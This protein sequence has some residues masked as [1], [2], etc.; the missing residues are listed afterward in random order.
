MIISSQTGCLFIQSIKFTYIAKAQEVI[1]L[2]TY[3]FLFPLSSLKTYRGT[4]FCYILPGNNLCYFSFN[5]DHNKKNAKFPHH[6]QS[7]HHTFIKS[8]PLN[9]QVCTFQILKKVL[10]QHLSDLSS[11]QI[12]YPPFYLITYTVVIH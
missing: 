12:L 11:F 7:H 10:F 9:Y 2:L 8:V 5:K 3:S 1:S 4:C 6:V